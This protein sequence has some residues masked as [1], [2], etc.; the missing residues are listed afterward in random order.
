MA[1]DSTKHLV[2]KLL[3]KKNLE[4]FLDALIKQYNVIAPVEQNGFS[5]YQK[6]TRGTECCLKYRLPRNSIK[7]FFLPQDETLFFFE[8]GA[9]SL[10][11]AP[12]AQRERIIFPVRPCDVR[13][14]T[15]LDAVF[16][17]EQFTD[18][19]YVEK[20]RKARLIGIACLEPDDTCFCETF[21]INSAD[22]TGCDLFMTEVEDAYVIDVLTA[23]GKALI[24]TLADAPQNLIQKK[25]HHVAARRKSQSLKLA[26]V[27]DFLKQGFE[28]ELWEELAAKCIGCGACAFL[29]PTCHCFDITDDVAGKIGRRLRSWDCCMFPKFTLHASGHNPRTKHAQRLRQ[30]IMHKFSY[31]PEN[32]S[33]IACVGCGRCVLAC[34]VNLDIR[35]ILGT[36][37]SATYPASPCSE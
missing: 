33:L 12:S 16:D 30:R 29:C 25:K 4:Q 21:D 27:Q 18:S 23:K 24:K 6:I 15:I 11:D 20:R 8:P 32:K 1:K 3:P 28:S 36:L 34:P 31:F 5:R 10:S 13:A 9:A 19:Y 17:D 14:L 7:E 37:A 2:S 22:G 26:E 35:E